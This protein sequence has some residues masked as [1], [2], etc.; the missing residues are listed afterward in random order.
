LREPLLEDAGRYKAKNSAKP[1]ETSFGGAQSTIS[2]SIEL[3]M[4]E[5]AELGMNRAYAVG[6]FDDDG[7]GRSDSRS[8]FL[9][10]RSDTGE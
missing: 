4:S 8:A 7:F 10:G 2:T 9:V 3:S 6:D 5:N 1:E